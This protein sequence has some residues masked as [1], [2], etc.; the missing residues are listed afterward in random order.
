MGSHIRP[1]MKGSVIAPPPVQQREAREV[2]N[3]TPPIEMETH[4]DGSWEI[5]LRIPDTLPRL[6]CKQ[7]HDSPRRYI[8]FGILDHGVS[9]SAI[10]KALDRPFAHVRRWADRSKPEMDPLPI[11]Y[12]DVDLLKSLFGL[13]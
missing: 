9:V 7:S 5:I 2:A 10:A 4:E 8:L 6:S 12:N 1:P 11:S 13:P 3:L